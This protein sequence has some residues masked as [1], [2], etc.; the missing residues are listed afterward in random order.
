MLKKSLEIQNLQTL[1][2]SVIPFVAL[3]VARVISPLWQAVA[4]SAPGNNN[5]YLLPTS[6]QSTAYH[7][8]FPGQRR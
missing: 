6:A 2:A 5:A 3:F 4:D 7:V 1:T 8:S